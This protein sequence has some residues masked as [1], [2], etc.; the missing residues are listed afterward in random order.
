VNL[1]CNATNDPDAVHPLQMH[2]YNSDGEQVTSDGEHVLVYNHSDPD[3]DHVQSMILFDHVNRSDDG[4]YTRRA[5]SD[6]NSTADLNTTLTVECKCCML[7]ACVCVCVHH[8]CLLNYGLGNLLLSSNLLSTKQD[9]Q[10]YEISIYIFYCMLPAF[11]NTLTLHFFDACL[12]IFHRFKYK[13]GDLQNVDFVARHHD[14]MHYRHTLKPAVFLKP[15]KTI[16]N[17]LKFNARQSKIKFFPGEIF[18]MF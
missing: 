9:Q 8:I 16:K 2:W 14:C 13:K 6:P 1:S 3:S 11:T 7:C 17:Y 15:C 18:I 12:S 4:T 5:F 10:L